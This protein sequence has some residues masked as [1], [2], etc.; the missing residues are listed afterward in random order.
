MTVRAGNQEGA[1]F[2]RV[3]DIELI[4]MFGMK[5]PDDPSFR[6]DLYNPMALAVR[7]EGIPVLQANATPGP[8]ESFSGPISIGPDDLLFL[9]DLKNSI[10]VRIGN[11]YI[12]IGQGIRIMGMMELLFKSPD[13]LPVSVHLNTSVIVPIGNQKSS[14]SQSK[15]LIRVVK[16]GPI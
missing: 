16:M 14:I 3:G 5:L 7:D 4:H 9:V 8:P 15:S 6:G 12:S 11:H 1:L 2:G 13:H 10:S